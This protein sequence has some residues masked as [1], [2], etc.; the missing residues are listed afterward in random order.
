[1]GRAKRIAV[2]GMLVLARVCVADLT[3]PASFEITEEE[4]S[5][6]R[7][8]L[9][10]PLIQ[11]R[12]LKAKPVFPATLQISGKPTSVGGQG[13]AT[14]TWQ[15]SMDPAALPGSAFGLSGLPGTVQDVRFTLNTL[16]GRR[17]QDVLRSTRAFFVVPQP[18]GVRELAPRACREG[19]RR[20][21]RHAGLWFLLIV[22]VLS[23]PT[24]ALTVRVVLVS[25]VGA[26]VA[27]AVGGPRLLLSLSCF[28]AAIVAL[29][30]SGRHATDEGSGR[31]R[32]WLALAALTGMLSAWGGM[33]TMPP[34]GLSSA[35]LRMAEGLV[36]GG[37]ILAGLGMGATVTL[38][39]ALFPRLA[40]RGGR[41]VLGLAAA[42]WICYHGAGVVHLYGPAWLAA[43]QRA[44]Q[45]FVHGWLLPF[46][47]DWAM[48][49][50][51]VPWLSLGILAGA[52]WLF[53]PALRTRRRLLAGG[54]L[55]LL[56]ILVLPVGASRFPVPFRS[57]EAPAPKQARRILEP[58]LGRIYRALNIEDESRAYDALAEDVSRELVGNLY[59]DSRRRLISGTREGASVVVRR[60]ELQDVGTPRTQSSGE[61][62]VVYPCRWTVTARVT[63]WQHRHD[64]RNL[65]EGDLRLSVEDDRWKIAGIDLHTEEREVVAGSFSSR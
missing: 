31:S 17:H 25:G 20:A 26:F 28:P 46:A 29:R 12:V 55:L 42:T 44:A 40:G 13:T 56:A 37:W 35:E 54:G 21:V 9:T 49:R 19:L 41:R 48:A 34:A 30:A 5:Q 32:R 38:A 63:H 45:A 43:L 58:A 15:G 50:L 16:D 11:G 53:R 33:M 18:P 60:I 4:P 1:M 24:R 65:Y 6:F 59:L 27:H 8:T 10:L 2:L 62:T 14:R 51:R 39:H 61:T 57:P 7:I 22:L 47:S 64:R 36:L 3:F 23:S 52:W